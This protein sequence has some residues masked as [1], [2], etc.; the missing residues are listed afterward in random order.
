M[1][2]LLLVSL[3][4][5]SS[6]GLIK[7]RLA[8][9]DP[10]AV[11]VLR[12]AAALAVFAPFLR[13]RLIPAALR[14]RLAA[15]GAVQFGVMYLLYLRSY[16]FLGAYQV[17]L[18]TIATP[19]WVVL[20]D[21]AVVRRWRL[22]YGLA[23]LLSI[24]GAAAVVAG[25]GIGSALFRGFVL[26]QLSNLCFAAGQVAWR[27]ERTRLDAGIP[28]KAVFGWLYV[29]ALV[30]SAAYSGAATRWSAFSPNPV[31]WATMA[32]LGVLASGAGFFWWNQGAT[33]VN[34]G[35]LAAFN[36]AKIPLGIASSVVLFGESA[37]W[38]RLLASG[39]FMGAAVWVAERPDRR[40]FS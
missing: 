21:A 34:A 8:N 11:A 7:T 22:R 24:V 32:Y 40:M 28:D 19:L 26:V 15:I 14:V 38:P 29:G 9:L 20:L 36:N 2:R 31:Q 5:A 6:F 13:P 37:D 16:A 35:T 1:I 33:R 17:A 23:A 25:H 10:A 3:I 39:L 18:F 30:L 4:W 27:F 12:L